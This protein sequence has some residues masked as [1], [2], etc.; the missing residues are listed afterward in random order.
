MWAHIFYGRI[1]YCNRPNLTQLLFNMGAMGDISKWGSLQGLGVMLFFLVLYLHYLILFYVFRLISKAG[2]RTPSKQWGNSR[3]LLNATV[4]QR[5]SCQRRWF[6]HQPREC[7]NPSLCSGSIICSSWR[8][9]AGSRL[10]RRGNKLS[11][12]WLKVP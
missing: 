4:K 7:W 10:G 8:C 11:R 6:W 9:Y 2:E 12:S 5:S 1:E 3:K